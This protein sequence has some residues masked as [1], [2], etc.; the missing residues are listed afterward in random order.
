MLN[1]LCNPTLALTKN[2]KE[3][4]RGDGW[5]D[6]LFFFFFFLFSFWMIITALSM[7]LLDSY[8][9]TSSCLFSQLRLYRTLPIQVDISLFPQKK[10]TIL[11]CSLYMLCCSCLVYHSTFALVFN[12]PVNATP[13]QCLNVVL[14]HHSFTPFTSFLQ[15][16]SIVSP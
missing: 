7:A 15:T 9:P 4:E 3:D 5:R 12:N 6:L 11:R 2:A 16:L 14:Y 8:S 10:C 13:N 1:T